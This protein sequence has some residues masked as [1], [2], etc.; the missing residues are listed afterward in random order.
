MIDLSKSC[1]RKLINSYELLFKDFRRNWKPVMLN[2]KLINNSS[3]KEILLKCWI[4]IIENK[5]KSM[6]IIWNKRWLVLAM[7]NDALDL[8]R[9]IGLSLTQLPTTSK[10]SEKSHRTATKSWSIV[11]IHHLKIIDQ[12]VCLESH[13]RRRIRDANDG[14]TILRKYFHPE[15]DCKKT[16]FSWLSWFEHV[17]WRRGA[18]RAAS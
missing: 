12:S 18:S 11:L 7:Q 1:C 16:Y 3:L 5:P 8:N 14:Q 9:K 2:I 15:I 17:S 13:F 4:W 10:I 6:K